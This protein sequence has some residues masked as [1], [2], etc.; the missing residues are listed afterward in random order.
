MSGVLNQL[1]WRNNTRF[2][3]LTGLFPVQ[4]SATF[5]DGVTNFSAATMVS[6]KVRT[7]PSRKITSPDEQK[8]DVVYS[9]RDVTRGF[10]PSNILSYGKWIK[11]GTRPYGPFE[12]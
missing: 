5:Q 3:E 10:S 8:Q 6:D 9:R 2:I 7:G 11:G 12:R 1:N 4:S